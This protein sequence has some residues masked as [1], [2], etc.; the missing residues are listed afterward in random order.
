MTNA[1]GRPPI[2]IAVIGGAGARTPLLVGG[3]TRSDLPIERIVLYDIDQERLRLIEAVAT[4]ACPAARL[5]TCRTSAEAIEGADYV[6]LSIRV[7]GIRQ[8]A[9]DEAVALAHGV[10]GQ[11]TIGPGGFAMAFRTIPHV[12]QYAA[13]VER[14]APRAWIINFTNPVGIITQAVLAHTGARIIGI[15]D[16]PTELFEE[17][18][19]VLGHPSV[20]CG[21]DYFGLNH[22]GWVREVYHRGEPQLHRLWND[23]AKLRQIYRAQLFEPQFLAALRLLPTEYLY[24]YYRSGDAFEHLRDA[25]R[26]RGQEIERLNERLFR[27]LQAPGVDIVSAYEEYLAARNAGYMQIESGAPAPIPRSAAA[28]LPGYDK[29]ALAVVRAIHFNSGAIIPLDVS[30]RG[31]LPEL[32]GDDVVEVP[33]VVN[34]NGAQPLHVGPPPSAVRDLILQ[35]KEYERLTIR[36]AVE[37]SE[38]LAVGALARNPLVAGPDLA[39]RLWRALEVA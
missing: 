15:C 24:Y 8:R 20:E 2:R 7:G 19:H 34:A 22:L 31:N 33:C 5:C 17:L 21:F 32:E 37:R 18:A 36:A 39:Q 4:R 1:S 13:E 26:T 12:L 10:V 27:D 3:L 29:I 30:N 23:E 16:T 28:V 6:F 38:S 9:R 14:L 11:E 25:G 35:V